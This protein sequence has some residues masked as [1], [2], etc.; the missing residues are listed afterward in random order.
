MVLYPDLA[1]LL[2]SLTDLMALSATARLAGL[3]LRWKRLLPA[4]ALGGL[5]GALCLL[6]P[7]KAAGGALWQALA[8]ALLIW[9]AFGASSLFFR[10]LLLFWLLSCML[11]GALLAAEELAQQG[12]DWKKLGHLDWKVFF[13]VGGGCY[14]LLSVVFRGAAKPGMRGQLC[15]CAVEYRGRRAELTALWDTGHTLTDAVTGEAVLVAEGE[16]LAALWTP[17]ERQVLARLP[18]EGAPWAMERLAGFRLLPY[19]AVGVSAGLLLCFQ[20]DR[21]VIGK[22]TYRRLTVAL[23]PTPVSDGGGYAALWGGEEGAGK[24]A[25]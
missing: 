2:N 17:E 23:S 16:A 3:P 25:A 13:L 12:W 6:P 10:Q 11:G 21:A 18:E 20:A 5:Y 8:A 9:V 24:H 22:Q 4:A 7:C 14:L 19:R 15:R 1:F